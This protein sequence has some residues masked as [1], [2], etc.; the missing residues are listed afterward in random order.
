MVADSAG[1]TVT[2]TTGDV[3]VVPWLSVTCAQ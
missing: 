1:L 2:V 3:A